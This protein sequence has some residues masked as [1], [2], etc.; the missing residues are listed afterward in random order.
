MRE[1]REA[2]AVLLTL[3]NAICDGWRSAVASD[4]K[5][6]GISVTTFLKHLESHALHFKAFMHDTRA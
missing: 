6:I 1:I 4:L 5:N 3:R 2:D